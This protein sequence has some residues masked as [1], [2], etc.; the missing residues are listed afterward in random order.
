MAKA[1]FLDDLG[2]LNLIVWTFLAGLLE[3]LAILDLT[4]IAP[5]CWEI[6]KAF[7]LAKP[8][9]FL[10]FLPETLNGSLDKIPVGRLTKNEDCFEVK[11]QIKSLD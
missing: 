9:A 1:T 3:F 11:L 4:M 10:V 6:P 8:E 7:S 5:S 2:L